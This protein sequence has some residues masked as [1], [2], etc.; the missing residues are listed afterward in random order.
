MAAFWEEL[1]EA[2]VVSGA[3]PVA[4]ETGSPWYIRVLLGISGWLAALFLLGFVA[5]GLEVLLDN[6]V[7]SF[8]SGGLCLAGAYLIFTRVRNDFTEQFGLA[9]SLAGQALVLWSMADLWSWEE[10]GPWLVTAGLQVVIAVIMPNFIQRF[11]SGYLA[12]CTLA[13]GLS[14]YGAFSLVPPLSA[15]LVALYWLREF[16]WQRLGSMLRPV[17]YGLTL[18]LLQ[19]QGYWL[20]GEE[21]KYFLISR[22]Q[23]DPWL[24]PWCDEVALAALLMFVVTHL[25]VRQ[26]RLWSGK[27]VLVTLLLT[28][29]VAAVSLKV[30]GMAT[31]LTILL[32]GF[33]GGN[34]IL[35]GL[36]VAALLFYLSGYYYFLQQTLLIKAGILAATG[37]V[38]LLARWVVLRWIFPLRE[39]Q[40]A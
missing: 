24:P 2:G 12:G 33:A 26:G 10:G 9:V 38:V 25:L 1:K 7:A 22:R 28:A 14:G 40:N 34:R 35:L 17:A 16:K 19:L 8:V 4:T 11:L 32:L 37:V 39:E 5:V 20:F 15:L 23:I 27:N 3:L 31:A 36:G 6:A 21:M 13:V 18:A 29:A 30:P